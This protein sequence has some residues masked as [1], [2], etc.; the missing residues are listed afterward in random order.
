[1]YIRQLVLDHP[2]VCGLILLFVSSS[3]SLPYLLYALGAADAVFRFDLLG[4]IG[5][6]LFLTAGII[7]FQTGDLGL[8][9]S[10]R[11]AV[12]RAIPTLA[13]ITGLG[14]AGR[15]PN[16]ENPGPPPPRRHTE[17][18]GHLPRAHG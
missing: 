7:L 2:D 15:A 16:T 1:M 13:V 10:V 17:P 3:S 8:A 5:T 9:I 18:L 12:L 14:A 4:G 11:G 6:S